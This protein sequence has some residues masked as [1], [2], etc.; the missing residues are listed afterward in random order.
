MKREERSREQIPA[1]GAAL[2]QIRS[3]VRLIAVAVTCTLFAYVFGKVVVTEIG[4]KSFYQAEAVFP[5]VLM[6]I[7]ESAEEGEPHFADSVKLDADDF[8][9]SQPFNA[10][11]KNIKC[12]ANGYYNGRVCEMTLVGWKENF[13]ALYYTGVADLSFLEGTPIL[14]VGYNIKSPEVVGNKVIVKYEDDCVALRLVLF[15]AALIVGIFICY[16]VVSFVVFLLAMCIL[17]KKDYRLYVDVMR[18]G[19]PFFV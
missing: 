8:I 4:R 19:P 3:T 14:L 5:E 11:W 16:K 2:R 10:V 12:N 7:L 1:A 13:P 6:G 17:K 15:S 18:S 9:G